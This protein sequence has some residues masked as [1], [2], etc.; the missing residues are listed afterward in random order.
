MHARLCSTAIAILTALC[1]F[2]SA[3]AATIGVIGNASWQ[4]TP[5]GGNATR[6]N[7]SNLVIDPLLNPIVRIDIAV[8]ASQGD[9]LGV[10][11]VVCN[12]VSPEAKDK[13]YF[14]NLINPEGHAGMF[15]TASGFNNTGFPAAQ[16]ISTAA[17]A[18]PIPCFEDLPNYQGGWGFTNGGLPHWGVTG[19]NPGSV[20][21]SGDTIA[22]TWSGDLAPNTPGI[23][24]FGRMGV[25]I[26]A[27]VA[28]PE[29]PNL[30]GQPLGFGADVANGVAG[31]G[32]EWWFHSL[33][34]DTT[35]WDRQT[36]TFQF[37]PTA[38]NVLRLNDASGNPFD[39]SQPHPGGFREAVTGA[40][41]FGGSVR[42]TLIPEPALSLVLFGA[43][44]LIRRR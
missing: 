1:S 19:A 27:N 24:S 40:N 2:A 35:N 18:A 36:Y 6:Q 23:Q 3:P 42:L 25:G 33:L 29:D 22:L 43:L 30:G 37:T 32:G 17:Y 26:G 14:F 20:I 12:T 11:Q 5:G 4:P 21:G 15:R 9:H 44:T 28:P 38:G 31:G 34:I 41:L 13:G 39:Y 8:V 10:S 16:D 7:G